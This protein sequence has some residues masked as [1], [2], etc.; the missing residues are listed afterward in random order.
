MDRPISFAPVAKTRAPA[1]PLLP[2]RMPRGWTITGRQLDR[3]DDWRAA[4]PTQWVYMPSGSTATS[5]PALVVGSVGDDQAP[6]SY[7]LGANVSE[8]SIG[9]PD[10]VTSDGA[11]V[12]GRGL[13]NAEVGRI[14]KSVR[15]RDPPR[16]PTVDLPPGYALRAASSLPAFGLPAAASLHVSGGGQT[17]QVGQEQAT[18]AGLFVAD[19]WRHV[20]GGHGCRQ[21]A[22]QRSVI[23]GGTVLRLVGQDTRRGRRMIRTVERRLARVSRDTFCAS[24]C[25]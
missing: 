8:E 16:P 7:C 5:G 25:D 4:L 3:S 21:G 20:L 1:R 19:F 22:S 11:Y 10:F 17:V 18:A 23:R 2:R 6:P 12:F 9:G 13:G 15:W 24:S 14:A